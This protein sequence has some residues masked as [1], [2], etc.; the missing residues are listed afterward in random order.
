LESGALVSEPG[1]DSYANLSDRVQEC[2]SKFVPLSA[3]V[4]SFLDIAL[5]GTRFGLFVESFLVSVFDTSDV[6]LPSRHLQRLTG[7]RKQIDV[8]L[9][10]IFGGKKGVCEKDKKMCPHS[11]ENTAAGDENSME[12]IRSQQQL[13]LEYRKAA[14]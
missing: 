5:S 2:H 11:S 4:L 6:S 9:S 8:L 3:T 12:M 14:S 1:Q 13:Q 7:Q 10:L